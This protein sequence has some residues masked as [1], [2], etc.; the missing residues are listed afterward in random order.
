MG[1][2]SSAAFLIYQYLGGS[3]E[4]LVRHTLASNNL[5][6]P[7]G[8]VVSL[9]P[10]PAPPSHTPSAFSFPWLCQ[11]EPFD[12][13]VH[14]NTLQVPTVSET[15]VVD[16]FERCKCDRQLDYCNFQACEL[17]HSLLISE[18]YVCYFCRCKGPATQGAA[19]C[20]WT[21]DSTA[22]NCVTGLPS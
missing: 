5:S 15:V 22:I 13:C 7:N 10:S 4:G 19:V 16:M 14:S 3:F 9:A 21:Y 20:R 6:I 17:W 2:S 12:T 11:A 18:R 1:P 8:K